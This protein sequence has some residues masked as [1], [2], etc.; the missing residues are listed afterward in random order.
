MKKFK[1]LGKVLC[2][3]LSLAMILSVF[4]SCGTNLGKPLLTLDETSISVNIYELYLSRMKGMLCSGAYFG[5]TATDAGFWD[6]WYDVGKRQTY[7]D[8]YSDIVLEDAKT[9]LA[10]LKIYDEKGLKLPQA[11]I[12]KVD[13][14]I[15][16]MMQNDANNSKNAFN[17]ILSDY[18]VNYD[19]Y[20]EACLIQEKI[21]YVSTTLF[22]AN[23]SKIGPDIIDK[24]YKDN[25]V[26]FR[27]IF[28]AS[29]EY[30][31]EIDAPKANDYGLEG[32]GDKIY[33]R[34][35]D[36]TKISY[37]TTATAKQKDDGTYVTDKNGDRVY[38]Y[39]DEDGNEHIAYNTK[40]AS[41]KYVLD[42][43]GNPVMREFTEE[44]MKILNSDAD[45]II[46]EAKEGDTAGFDV[47]V[48]DYNQDDTT[49]KYPNGHYVSKTMNYDLI[50]VIEKVMDMK[51][52]EIKK[53][54][55]DY[56][57]HIIMRYELQ[58][59]GYALEG[60]EEFFVNSKTGTYS[61][62]SDLIDQLM[63][64]Y[65][66]DDIKK[67]KVDTELLKTIDIKRAGVNYYY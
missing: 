7:N 66:K 29:Y 56:G 17:S 31:Y 48:N 58:D 67:I 55:S 28:L 26:R 61:F 54:P 65:V 32:Y 22:G 9:Y 41:T 15:N 23:G 3:F 57:I 30:E 24:Y 5:E 1:L 62:M 18:G 2:I 19:M 6:T 47:L 25:Y 4:A 14:E 36:G 13:A 27:Q 49:E 35:D 52:G 45:A 50:D 60:N 39:T 63:Y 20:R 53:I 59:Q 34:D 12:D 21:E 38:F 11:T 10:I 33:F 37:D 8:F 51:I 16:E 44:E 42:S 40:N 46:A 43:E 64:D